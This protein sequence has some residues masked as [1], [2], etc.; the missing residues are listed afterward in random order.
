MHSALDVADR[1]EDRGAARAPLRTRIAPRPPAMSAASRRSRHWSSPCVVVMLSIAFGAVS[2][3]GGADR[4]DRPDATTAELAPGAES[5]NWNFERGDFA[6][7]RTLA[8]GSG[9]WHVYADG[10]TPPDPADSD[11]H[12]VF[13]VPPPPEGKFAAVTD[14]RAPGARILHRTLKLDGR[15]K[16]RL[17]LFYES[18]GGFSSPPSLAFHLEQPNKQFRVELLAATAPVT[19][20]AAKHVLA[21]IF[22]TSPGD[23]SS[24]RP[25][26]VTVDLSRWAGQNVRLRLAQVDNQGPLRAGVDNIRLDR[27]GSRP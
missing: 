8:F 25:H 16:L 27:I 26:E 22:Q 7:W 24:V 9:A 10:T 1:P 2:G 15:F 5:A 4:T 11:P 18:V 19:S 3:C 14:M 17:T 13:K 12:S 20:M 23:R 21:T 6:G